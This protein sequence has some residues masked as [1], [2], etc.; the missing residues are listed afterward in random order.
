MELEG[1]SRSV[2]YLLEH[3]LSIGTI[4]TDRH[5]SIRKG[6]KN[7]LP[8]TTHSYDV[9]HVAKGTYTYSASCNIIIIY[10]I[11]LIVILFHSFLHLSF[12][13]HVQA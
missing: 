11:I 12:S 5:K 6:I 7:A 3:K 4:V 9:W 10:H 8:E 13:K 2:S 1:L